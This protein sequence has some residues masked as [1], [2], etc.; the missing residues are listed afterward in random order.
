MKS[1]DGPEQQRQSTFDHTIRSFDRT[2]SDR[3]WAGAG[4]DGNKAMQCHGFTLDSRWW[5][6]A[7]NEI[8]SGE[9]LGRRI[10]PHDLSALMFSSNLFHA[11]LCHYPG[12]SAKNVS[13]LVRDSMPLKKT[14]RCCIDIGCHH[15]K[16]ALLALIWLVLLTKTLGNSASR[17]VYCF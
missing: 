17:P 9:R 15:E 16:I 14:L 2:W 1:R 6:R 10:G 8:L 5:R 3:L 11:S 13:H 12:S 4:Y 7:S